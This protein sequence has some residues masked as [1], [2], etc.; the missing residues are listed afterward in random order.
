MMT[1]NCPKCNTQMNFVYID[2]IMVDCDPDDWREALCSHFPPLYTHLR[3]KDFKRVANRVKEKEE[4][5]TRLRNSWH[6]IPFH[7]HTQIGPLCFMDQGAHR[8]YVNSGFCVFGKVF[9]VYISRYL[10]YYLIP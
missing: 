6:K 4:T 9:G 8:D 3:P 10:Y 1:A 7:L 5:L 2:K